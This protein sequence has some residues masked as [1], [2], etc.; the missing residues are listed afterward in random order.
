LAAPAP[1]ETTP[2]AATAPADEAGL[3]GPDRGLGDGRSGGARSGEG[4]PVGAGAETGGF[5]SAGPRD[6]AD[7]LRATTA[8]P[9]ERLAV[10]L[11]RPLLLRGFFLSRLPL[12]LAAGLRLRA[13]DRRRCV[14]TV[15]YGWR[16]TNPFRSTYFAALSMAAELSTGALGMLATRSAPAPVALLIVGLEATFEKKA[17]ALTTF[18]C[19]DG[20]AIFAAVAETLETGEP[21]VVRAESVGRAPDGVELAR[22]TFDW[23]FKRRAAR[24]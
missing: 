17:T 22:F 10:R 21:A 4:E 20:D 11:A 16:T 9:A 14:V 2:A 18:T 12:A 19:A 7:L 15:P 23:S 3:H 1:S 5:G 8:W 6:R 24:A 13:I